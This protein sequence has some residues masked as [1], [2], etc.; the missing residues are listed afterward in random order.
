M[1][2]YTKIAIGTQK[3]KLNLSFVFFVFVFALFFCERSVPVESCRVNTISRQVDK[4]RK[5]F[6]FRSYGI[7][8]R[9]KA[10]RLGVKSQKRTHWYKTRRKKI[11]NK[12]ETFA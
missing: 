2:V 6:P 1:Q 12:R 4:G 8:E 7:G 10:W 3:I 5:H 11:R 9:K